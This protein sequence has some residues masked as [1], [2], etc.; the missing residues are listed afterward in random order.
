MLDF[1]AMAD[2][3]SP[4]DDISGLWGP[5]HEGVLTPAMPSPRTDEP[6]FVMPASTNGNGNGSANGHGTGARPTMLERETH[7]DVA[8]L[9]RAIA[10]S[11]VD[12]VRPADLQAAR[13]EV[14]GAFTQQLAVALYELMAATNARF[15]TAEDHIK[16]RVNEAVEVHAYR[17]AATLEANHRAT[18]EMSELM[19]TQIDGLCQRLV[20]P[21]DGLADIQRELRHEVGRLGD[22]VA[23]QGQDQGRETAPRTEPEVEQRD[24]HDERTMKAAEERRN[25]SGLLAA[26]RDDLALLR[27][28]VAELRA[29][30]RDVQ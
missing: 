18:S 27:D 25:V 26:V 19:R 29:A 20:G 12:R 7:E 1:L 23:A 13:A 14:E 2:Y 11:H 4:P 8:R 22:M 21:V 16:Q 15:A 9:A 17:L 28:E 5:E 30:V 24:G 6:D 10:E 3:G